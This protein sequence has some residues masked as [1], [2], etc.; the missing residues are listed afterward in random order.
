MADFMRWMTACEGGALWER[1][2]F[3]RAYANNRTRATADVIESDLLAQAVERFI[4]DQGG[5]WEGETTPLL[6]ELN[7]LV[8]D[9][10][11]NNKQWPKAANTLS[12][13]LTRA[14]SSLR[15]AGIDVRAKRNRENRR[16]WK[17]A[18]ISLASFDP[19][20]GGDLKQFFTKDMPKD[21]GDAA[22]DAG[23]QP[24]LGANPLKNVKIKGSK[25]GDDPLHTDKSAGQQRAR[26]LPAYFVVGSEEHQARCEEVRQ[27]WL[28]SRN[29]RQDPSMMK[30]Q[31]GGP[32]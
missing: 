19:L 29:Y 13:K 26:S 9:E 12:G 11:R 7:T 10:T 5:A 25:D 3:A 22:K 28:A 17:I 6:T 18:K 32:L 1:G 30:T 16:V 20:K 8:D 15:R 27:A 23:V 31:D 24:S 21:A 14:A 4:E 2:T